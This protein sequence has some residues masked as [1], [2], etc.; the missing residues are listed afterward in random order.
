[1]TRVKKTRFANF[2]PLLWH[3]HQNRKIRSF[4]NKLMSATELALEIRFFL[5][6]LIYSFNLFRWRLNEAIY[7][8]RGR[9]DCKSSFLVTASK[10]GNPNF[11]K[12]A[13][14]FGF[15][16]YWISSIILTT[17]VIPLIKFSIEGVSFC[18]NIL[19]I[20]TRAF[21][22]CIRVLIVK[23]IQRARQGVSDDQIH[24]IP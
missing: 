24:T 15:L 11:P 19:H 18:G 5:Q 2:A 4:R 9:S 23:K 21:V 14:S 6:L 20:K 13:D 8:C 7:I 16:P 22:L 3:V 10:S 1:M 17:G 12:R